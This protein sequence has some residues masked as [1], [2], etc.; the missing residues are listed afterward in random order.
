MKRLI[1]LAVIFIAGCTSQQSDQLTQQQ[2]DQIKSELNVI[3]DS[4]IARFA[5]LDTD[6]AMQYYWD[7]PDFIAVNPDGSRFDFQAMK[8]AHVD[9]FSSTASLKILVT[10][11]D[12][13][14]LTR[15]IAI[16]AAV[17]KSEITLK[18]GDK[19]VFDPN[20][21]TLVF[22]K[23]AGEWKVIL[24]QQSTAIAMQGAGKK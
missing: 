10:R 20:S 12:F 17:L 23:I 2:K 4:I 13:M 21:L 7:S 18:S 16:D 3:S 9:L 11:E 19:M 24:S 15:D 8:K 22:R 14:V 6:G 5:R 1:L